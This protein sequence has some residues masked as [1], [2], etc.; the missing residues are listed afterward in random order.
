MFTHTHARTPVLPM[1]GLLLSGCVLA[2]DAD[3][4]SQLPP[5]EQDDISAVSEPLNGRV[6]YSSGPN[7]PVSNGTVSPFTAALWERAMFYNRVVANSE[8]F[9]SCV[10]AT[11]SQYYMN[12]DDDSPT[13]VPSQAGTEVLA[14]LSEWNNDVFLDS[15]PGAWDYTAYAGHQGYRTYNRHGIQVSERGRAT[16]DHWR[17]YG[18]EAL[19]PA[20]QLCVGGTLPTPSTACDFWPWHIWAGSAIHEF[21]HTHNY[22][23]M[24]ASCGGANCTDP[25]CQWTRTRPDGGGCGGSGTPPAGMTIEN[26]SPARR[27]FCAWLRRGDDRAYYLDGI[28]PSAPYIMGNCAAALVYQSHQ[29]CGK[30]TNGCGPG[31]LRLLSS[32]QGFYNEEQS[33]SSSGCTCVSDPRHVVALRTPSYYYLTAAGGGGGGIWPWYSG[34][35]GAWQWF[36]MIDLNRGSLV[37]GDPI[38]VKTFQ[39]A[40]DVNGVPAGSWMTP[41]FSATGTSPTTLTIYNNG[42][43]SIGNNSSIRLRYTPSGWW[44]NADTANLTYTSSMSLSTSFTVYEPRREHLVYFRTY[45]N[46]YVEAPSAGGVLAYNRRTEAELYNGTEQQQGESA[47]WVLDHNGGQLLSGDSISLETFWGESYHYLSTWE[48]GTGQLRGRNSL[49]DYERFVVTK[50]SG[51]PG[52]VIGHNDV[53]VLRSAQGNYLT[54]MPSSYGSSELRNYVS[55][56]GNWER[57]TVR[58]V[59]QHDRAV[60]SIQCPSQACPGG[61]VCLNGRCSCNAS[62]SCGTDAGCAFMRSCAS[63]NDCEAGSCY[64]LIPGVQPGTCG[65]CSTPNL[66]PGVVSRPTW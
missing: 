34:N 13:T 55:T 59:S 21:S 43:G 10:T 6:S 22:R 12:C 7:P 47:F 50:V 11:M 56:P 46:R 35:Q 3:S 32:W 8:A 44:A 23:H 53:I 51:S 57:L 26:A 29:A 52:T 19:T 66:A 37:H 1:C 5:E 17:W 16:N 25:N 63:N 38:Q 9:R 14:M 30:A 58:M 64:G 40:L 33:D 45:H 62:L 42:S 20:G 39:G 24:D 60:S 61:S 31:Q 41:W 36:Y 28:D 4:A 65:V 49:G 54:A 15:V 27:E 48:G 2:T 18:D